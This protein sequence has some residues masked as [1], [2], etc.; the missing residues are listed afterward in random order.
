MDVYNIGRRPH[1]HRVCGTVIWQ[2]FPKSGMA[3]RFPYPPL[4]R[5]SDTDYIC[6]TDDKT[7]ASSQW[8]VCFMESLESDAIESRLS[9]YSLR[10][11]LEPR[12]IQMGFLSEDTFNENVITDLIEDSVDM[13]ALLVN[14]NDCRNRGDMDDAVRLFAQVMSLSIEKDDKWMGEGGFLGLMLSLYGL[15]DQRIFQWYPKLEQTFPLDTAE[16][17]AVAWCM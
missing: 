2:V 9:Q 12:Q 8:D 17:A 11:H 16:K 7:V 4:Y 15:G 5:Q 14:A 6:F 13:H 3:R 1:S 10:Y